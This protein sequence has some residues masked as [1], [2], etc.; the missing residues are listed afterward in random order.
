MGLIS[1]GLLSQGLRLFQSGSQHIE[2]EVTFLA[3]PRKPNENPA[4]RRPPA[5]TP[6]ARER[7]LVALAVDL[8]EKQ[9][10]EGTASAQVITHY[11]KLGTTREALEQQK[12]KRE[13]ILLEARSNAMA[14]AERIEELYGNAIKAMREY[15]G[16]QLP[17]DE[18]EE[19][20]GF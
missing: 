16:Q 11:L 14:S 5:K 2:Q 1:L 7:Q 9:I 18:E 13:N 8:A 3:A 19:P 4:P 15:S 20:Y 12:L 6:E 17:P 10:R